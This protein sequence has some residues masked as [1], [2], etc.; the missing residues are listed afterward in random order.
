VA[1][2]AGWP[3]TP[4]PLRGGSEASASESASRS[5]PILLAGRLSVASSSGWRSSKALAAEARI[6]LLDEPTAVL[7]PGEVDE[8][9]RVMRAFSESGGSVV[10]IT[11][12]LD[13]ALAVASRVTCFVRVASSHRPGCRQ[14]PRYWP[15]RWS[16]TPSSNCLGARRG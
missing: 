3:V 12:K 14:T 2:A 1:L 5:I 8:L 4:A 11:H 13:E 16:A 6:L 10:L 9:F 15:G 7:A